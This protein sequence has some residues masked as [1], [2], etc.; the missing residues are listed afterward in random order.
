MTFSACCRRIENAYASIGH[1]LGW[2]F[3]YSPRRTY[4]KDVDLLL[5]GTNPGGRVF[6]DSIPSVETG[7]AYRTEPWDCGRL[8]RLQRQVCY[9]FEQMS[10]ICSL[11]ADQLMDDTLTANFCP[12]RSSSWSSLHAREDSLIFSRDLWRGIMT[13]TRPKIIISIGHLPYHETYSLFRGMSF[14]ESSN[15]RIPTGWG[16]IM[17]HS[18]VLTREESS[19]LLLGLPH[20]SR[21]SI[22]GRDDSSIF[23][24]PLGQMIKKQLV[25]E[26]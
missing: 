17:I 9:L 25:A 19:V 18:A 13:F 14:D 7:N 16:S 3:L 6:E 12:F 15:E 2:R 23:A 21:F 11:S 10:P 20:L 8:N 4:R 22:F 5:L 24:N 26:P 1:S